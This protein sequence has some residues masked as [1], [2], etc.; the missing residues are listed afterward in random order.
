VVNYRKIY[1][2]L[3]QQNIVFIKCIFLEKYYYFNQIMILPVLVPNLEVNKYIHC[4]NLHEKINEKIFT[5]NKLQPVIP[6]IIYLRNGQSICK[7]PNDHQI[8][9]KFNE[10]HI[11]IIH[12]EHLDTKKYFDRK[13]Y[14]T[15][16][17][18]YSL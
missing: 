6:H 16:S 8:V 12:N 14:V 13:K 18:I 5:F 7:I 11:L 2:K 4:D 15:N 3:N 10:N 1:K 9:I 17:N